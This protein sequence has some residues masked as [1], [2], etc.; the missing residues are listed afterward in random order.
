[1]LDNLD[2][3]KT[4]PNVKIPG[5]TTKWVAYDGDQIVAEGMDMAEVYVNAAILSKSKPILKRILL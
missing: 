4:H 3:P 2:V 1:M 5:F